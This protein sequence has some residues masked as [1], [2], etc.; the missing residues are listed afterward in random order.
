MVRS[1]VISDGMLSLSR[2]HGLTE[3]R[4]SITLLCSASIPESQI[5]VDHQ[6]R[7]FWDAVY[8]Q[9]DQLGDRISNLGRSF[10]RTL[11]LDLPFDLCPNALAFGIAGPSQPRCPLFSD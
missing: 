8:D 3:G 9:L 11:H 4:E 2:A 7:Y 1:G 5:D 6:R 10:V